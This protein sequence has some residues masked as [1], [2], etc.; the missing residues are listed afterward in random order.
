MVGVATGQDGAAGAIA[1]PERGWEAEGGRLRLRHGE[2]PAAATRLEGPWPAVG[3]GERL[4]EK[5]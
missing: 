4:P 1:A 3:F 5:P 2:A